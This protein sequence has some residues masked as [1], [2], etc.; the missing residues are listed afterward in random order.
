M[1]QVLDNDWS[2]WRRLLSKGRRGLEQPID[3]SRHP[4]IEAVNLKVKP[5]PSRALP[6]VGVDGSQIYPEDSE[7]IWAYALAGSF[8]RLTISIHSSADVI[9]L[10]PAGQCRWISSQERDRFMARNN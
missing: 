2:K 3:G 4:H 6:A 10:Q 7:P 5:N 1:L 9:E 8:L